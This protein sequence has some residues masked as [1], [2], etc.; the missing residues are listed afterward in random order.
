M[1]PTGV[2]VEPSVLCVRMGEESSCRSRLPEPGPSAALLTPP[3]TL[4]LKLGPK[5][6]LGH[7][8]SKEAAATV[9]FVSD[10][11]YSP[12]V[13]LFSTRGVHS[14]GEPNAD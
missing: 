6:R 8:V 4:L 10:A 3:P 12:S 5:L 11:F 2:G 14:Q 7:E 9:P 13:F 1:A